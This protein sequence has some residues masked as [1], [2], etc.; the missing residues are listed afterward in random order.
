[1]RGRHGYVHCEAIEDFSRF[2]ERFDASVGSF[3]KCCVRVL[4][5][6]N[7]QLAE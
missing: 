7:R 1:M 5:H 3:G 4:G 2:L 6:G